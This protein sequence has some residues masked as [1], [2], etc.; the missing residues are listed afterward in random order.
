MKEY[1]IQSKSGIH[2][3]LSEGDMIKIID[4]EGKQVVDFF[5]VNEMN[6]NEILSPGVTIDCNGG[7][8]TPIKVV[9]T[10]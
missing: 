4:I 6:S 7:R 10:E 3:R 9:V 5:A 2:I 1:I 8:C